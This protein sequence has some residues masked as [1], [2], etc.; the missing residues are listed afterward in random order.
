M[1]QF[2][3]SNSGRDVNV[4]NIRTVCT[5]INS[6]EYSKALP[7][8]TSIS[9]A[10]HRIAACYPKRLYCV[11][12]PGPPETFPTVIGR[13]YDLLGEGDLGIETSSG[14]EC[15]KREV[16]YRHYYKLSFSKTP[17][18]F[19]A[20]HERGP[21]I[22]FFRHFSSCTINLHDNLHVF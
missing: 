4:N 17:H 22:F 6:L 9:I 10:S 7:H 16:L 8:D 20:I 11:Q 3:L 5:K 12:W 14:H 21:H 2:I 18:T 15:L 1:K 19:W 13:L